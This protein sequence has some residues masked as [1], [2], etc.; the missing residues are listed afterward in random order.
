[1]D[2]VADFFNDSSFIFVFILGAAGG[3]MGGILAGRQASAA[4]SVIIGAVF[5]VIVSIVAA[6]FN[7]PSLVS[8]GGFPL[9]WAAGG[10]LVAAYVISRSSD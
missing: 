7:A 5:G 10:G 4:S 2:L 8:V 3:L 1:M 9:V 6:F